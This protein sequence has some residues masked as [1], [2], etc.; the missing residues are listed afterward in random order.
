L[1]RKY[2]YIRVSS[3]DQNIERQKNAMRKV[4]IRDDYLF[5]DKQSGKDFSR[6]AYQK[7]VKQ[8][9]ES[10]VIFIDSIDRLGRNYQE[11]L[12]EWRIL[13]KEKKVDI[14]VL[15]MPILDTRS[16]LTQEDLTKT[17]VAD[18][19]LQI[20]SYVAEKERQDIRRRQAE[21]I[22]AAKA[23]GVKFGN[24]GIPI[25]ENFAEVVA[26]WRKKEISL[27]GALSIL[28]VSRSYFYDKVKKLGL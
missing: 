20:L 21:G 19:V 6:P 11:I 16:S 12:E 25:P 8:C 9:Q 3:D 10:D 7:L 28:E 4:G 22:A 14:V 24:P 5:I 13:T 27:D 23:R 2:G 26:R 17:F 1:N 18:L 15:D